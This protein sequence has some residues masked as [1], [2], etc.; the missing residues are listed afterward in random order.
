MGIPG[1][2]MFFCPWNDRLGVSVMHNGAGIG[3]YDIKAGLY[4][5]AM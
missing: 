4:D 2:N 5:L 1:I 3:I